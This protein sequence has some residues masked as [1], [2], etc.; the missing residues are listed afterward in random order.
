MSK[1]EMMVKGYE[2]S[3]AQFDAYRQENA[4]VEVCTKAAPVETIL[5]FWAEN[6]HTR[7]DTSHGSHLDACE[8]M[9]CDGYATA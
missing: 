5:R 2:E 9:Q 4:N 8:I 3:I 6:K 7:H 1:F